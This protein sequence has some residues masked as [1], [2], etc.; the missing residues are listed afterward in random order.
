MSPQCAF[1]HADA[2]SD[3]RMSEPPLHARIRGELEAR[4]RGG[5]WVPG[6]RIP[7]EADLGAEFGV[8]RITVQRALRDLA[9]AGLIVR[10]RGRG[11][12]VAQTVSQGNLLRFTG[13]LT[14][15]P[16]SHGDHRVI[17]AQVIPAAEAR[18]R[19]PGVPGDEAVVQ[20]ERHKLNPRDGPSTRSCTCCRSG[21]P[22]T[23]STRT[24]R[25]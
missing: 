10:F 21:S 8:S 18:L 13:L 1:A 25:P 3:H 5:R 20:M 14:Q 23:Y 16:E 24:S 2:H 22:P 4:I 9:E 11:S 17:K 12:L 6:T 7:T 15:G 19:L